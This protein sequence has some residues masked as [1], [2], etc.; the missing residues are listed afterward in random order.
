MTSIGVGDNLLNAA[1]IN[2]Y[3]DT[4]FD[5]GSNGKP[6]RRQQYLSPINYHG[7][8]CQSASITRR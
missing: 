1:Y 8:V 5:E 4:K 2:Q 3:F 6:T 7:D